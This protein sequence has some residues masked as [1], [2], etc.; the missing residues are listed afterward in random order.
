MEV[1]VSGRNETSQTQ[2]RKS[3]TL[4]A[5]CDS[6]YDDAPPMAD[7]SNRLTVLMPPGMQVWGDS[8]VI[9][10]I[11]SDVRPSLADAGHAAQ[12]MPS[13]ADATTEQSLESGFW[14]TAG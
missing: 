9:K 5:S 1:F 4:Q 8:M 6:V 10:L 3:R 2:S 13:A 14:A 12:A 7:P 11:T